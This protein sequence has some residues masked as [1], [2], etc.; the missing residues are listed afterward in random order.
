MKW[1]KRAGGAK[2]EGMKWKWNG[3]N[4]EIIKW[5]KRENDNNNEGKMMINENIDNENNISDNGN[6]NESKNMA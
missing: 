4:E 5:R 2:K 1:R 3:V 6:V